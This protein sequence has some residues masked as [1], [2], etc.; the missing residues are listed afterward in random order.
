MMAARCCPESRDAAPGLTISRIVVKQVEMA[1]RGTTIERVSSTWGKVLHSR[2]SG[3]T[4]VSNP[5]G[6]SY[7]LIKNAWTEMAQEER[8]PLPVL[9]TKAE[10]TTAR[11]GR[12]P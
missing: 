2:I 12:L 1:D 3:P 5:G 10:P 11:R 6:E 9:A 7:C 8:L 4:P